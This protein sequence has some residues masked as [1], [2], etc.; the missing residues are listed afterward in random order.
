ME[1]PNLNFK[2]Q[3]SKAYAYCIQIAKD[4]QGIFQESFSK[5]AFMKEK[6]LS[7]LSTVAV[8]Y[9]MCYSLIS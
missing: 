1:N 6:Q 9:L 7:W 2:N 8:F 4:P 3:P 5:K